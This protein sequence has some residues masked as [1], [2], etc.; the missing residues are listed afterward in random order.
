M[1][2]KTNTPHGKELVAKYGKEKSVKFVGGIYDFNKLNSIR[3][4]LRLIS[5]VI[6]WVVP[7]LLCWKRWLLNV[8]S[9]LMIIFLIV[10]C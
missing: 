8:L 1:V 2:G 10:L 7:I 9:L 4:S 5:M 3:L 6:V